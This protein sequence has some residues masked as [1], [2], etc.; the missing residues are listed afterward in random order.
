[1]ILLLP[2]HRIG[3]AVN[4][5]QFLPRINVMNHTTKYLLRSPLDDFLA[6][7]EKN[8]MAAPKVL[9]HI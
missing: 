7:D 4:P 9:V 8:I 6:W 5:Y 1:L 2:L 3:R